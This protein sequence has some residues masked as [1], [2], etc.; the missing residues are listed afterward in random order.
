MAILSVL[1]ENYSFFFQKICVVCILHKIPFIERIVMA[2]FQ[3]F[4]S[5]KKII[6][7]SKISMSLNAEQRIKTSFL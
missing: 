7:N 3:I 5:F 6:G 1:Y 4:L 2:K